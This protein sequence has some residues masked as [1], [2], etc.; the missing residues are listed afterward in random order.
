MAM[1]HSF[2][3]SDDDNIA[4]EITIK[5]VTLDGAFIARCSLELEPLRLVPVPVSCRYW[6]GR[7]RLTV[8]TKG[9]HGMK[10]TASTSGGCN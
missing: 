7:G 6:A 3:S 8:R 1:A 10:T 4:Q 9:Y 5:A 2:G